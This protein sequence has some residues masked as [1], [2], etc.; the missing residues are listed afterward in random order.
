[1]KMH[2]ARYRKCSCANPTDDRVANGVLCCE[3][4]DDPPCQFVAKF[5]C[6]IYTKV[7]G[8][9][10]K[11]N[12]HN[13]GDLFLLKECFRGCKWLAKWGMTAPPP[14]CVV[15]DDYGNPGCWADAN[16][17]GSNC[18]WWFS[19]VLCSEIVATHTMWTLE[20]VDATT[21]T[22]TVTPITGGTGVYT[23]DTFDCTARNDFVYDSAGATDN[24]KH[25]PC[26]V[27]V[28]PVNTESEPA[29]KCE[30][31]DDQCDCCDNGGDTMTF[32][33]AITGCAALESVTTI[34]TTRVCDPEAM[35]CGITYPSPA[36]CCVFVGDISTGDGCTFEGTGYTG[37][38]RLIIYCVGLDDYAIDVYCQKNDLC[39]E[40]Q[41]TI[42]TTTVCTCN[43]PYLEFT[44]PE[45]NCCCPSTPIDT[46]CCPT[47][48]PSV[49]TAFDGTNTVT[50]TYTPSSWIL[51]PT[52]GSTFAGCTFTSGVG[53]SIALTCF[54]GGFWMFSIDDGSGAL[55][56]TCSP[57]GDCD[58]VDLTCTITGCD[59][60][61]YTINI[62][63]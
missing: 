51:T 43:G 9:Y 32:D 52:P 61:I 48:M 1:M 3:F 58:P 59:L 27:C 56:V 6:N 63:E 12:I 60:G 15:P 22:L 37:L 8:E 45:L 23:C 4:C 14:T 50:L 31:K 44:L 21:A 11:E 7:T 57:T 41:G 20:I 47:P 16:V 5:D 55:P 24:L 49:L 36:P 33:V 26:G 35:A 54:G 25:L 2:R 30:T 28:A 10:V 29:L 19:D 17:V 38:V 42:G 62:T 39:F 13:G 53:R 40:S 34:N 46:D 18:C